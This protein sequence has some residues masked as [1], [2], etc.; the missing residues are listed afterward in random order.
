MSRAGTGGKDGRGL[1]GPGTGGPGTGGR[2]RG[3]P[4]DPGRARARTRLAWTRTALAFAAIGGVILKRDLAAGSWCWR[5]A[6]WS[7]SWAGW[8]SCP[9]RCGPARAPCW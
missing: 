7:G 5:W 2:G 9:A 3:A 1:A 6:A 8:L 4:D